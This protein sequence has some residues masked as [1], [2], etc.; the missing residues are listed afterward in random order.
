[1][2]SEGRVPLG[3]PVSGLLSDALAV[4]TEMFATQ[5][6]RAVS[7][8]ER[9]ADAFRAAGEAEGAEFWTLVSRVVRELARDKGR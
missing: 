6:K 2:A 1:M 4:G 7:D 3:W 5:G 9:R 8:I